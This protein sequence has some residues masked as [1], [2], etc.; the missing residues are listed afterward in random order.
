MTLAIIHYS[1]PYNIHGSNISAN[2]LLLTLHVLTSPPAHWTFTLF[3][4]LACGRRSSYFLLKIT[5]PEICFWRLYSCSIEVESSFL[6]VC[7]QK[8]LRSH[9]CWIYLAL[10]GSIINYCSAMPR[11]PHIVSIQL[12]L[13][14]LLPNAIWFLLADHNPFP[15]RWE[16]VEEGG[17]R[18]EETRSGTEKGCSHNLQSGNLSWWSAVDNCSVIYIIFHKVNISESRRNNSTNEKMV[19]CLFVFL[20]NFVLWSWNCKTAIEY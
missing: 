3:N 12:L 1:K 17:G 19:S 13:S 18:G 16:Q 5:I 10:V 2:S 6:E 15:A 11:H 14:S 4:P 9:R 20:C 8:L 7:L